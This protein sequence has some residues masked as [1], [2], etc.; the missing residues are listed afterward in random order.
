MSKNRIEVSETN[1]EQTE[2]TIEEFLA[3]LKTELP[4]KLRTRILFLNEEL[5]NS[6]DL[7]DENNRLAKNIEEVTMINTNYLSRIVNLQ[8]NILEL[9]DILKQAGFTE[10]TEKPDGL[11]K[12]VIEVEV[13]KEGK[14]TKKT[15]EIDGVKIT[16]E[17]GYYAGELYKTKEDF[18][19]VHDVTLDIKVESD[20]E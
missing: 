19:S 5:L 14:Q 16:E 7:V 9:K 11:D 2:Q 4:D 17:D 15:I 13:Q 8:E 18:E 12:E 1:N 10:V 3:I 20:E 6:K